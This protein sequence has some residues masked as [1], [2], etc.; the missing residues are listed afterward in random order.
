GHHQTNE[1]RE[2][3]KSFGRM[4]WGQFGNRQGV[5]RILE[6]LK[7][8]SAPATFYVPG[9]VALLYGDEQRRIIAEG[10]E[11]GIHSWIHEL[12]SVL[13]YDAEKDLMLRAADVLEKTTKVRPVG[14][15]TASWDFSPYTLR[16]TKEVDL[17]YDSSLM[18]GGACAAPF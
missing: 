13:P 6:I 12:N 3:G 1:L 9:V 16:I 8:H 14:A 11:I 2:G 15:R 4:S 10:H 18:A 17:L 7:R 5:P